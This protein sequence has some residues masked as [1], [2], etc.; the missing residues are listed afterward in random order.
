MIQF[1]MEQHKVTNNPSVEDIL[2]TE[3]WVYETIESRW[4]S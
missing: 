1:C 2:E 4:N 3:K